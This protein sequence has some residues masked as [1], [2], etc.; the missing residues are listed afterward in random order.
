MTHQHH[1]Y[2][3]ETEAPPCVDLGHGV[4]IR[5]WGQSDQF[6]VAHERA[7]GYDERIHASERCE[8]RVPTHPAGQAHPDHASWERTGSLE[9]GDL[10]LKPSIQ[11]LDPDGICG[12]SH[13][14]VTNT[15]WVPA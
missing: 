12:G 2:G 3:L 9:G 14:F 6:F 13:G 15:Q 1:P 7:S 5:R 8:G 4:C 10:T 11:C